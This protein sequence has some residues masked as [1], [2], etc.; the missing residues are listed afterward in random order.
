M[1]GATRYKDGGIKR[2]GC[3]DRAHRRARMSF[4]INVGVGK[5]GVATAINF[6]AGAGLTLGEHADN[7]TCLFLRWIAIKNHSGIS[8]RGANTVGV[9]CILQYAVTHLKIA[10]GIDGVAKQ[11]YLAI[12]HLTAGGSQ[13]NR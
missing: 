1:L 9:D 6:T 3:N 5:H 12:F 7:L 8:K 2:D 4:V 10:A 13:R 11:K